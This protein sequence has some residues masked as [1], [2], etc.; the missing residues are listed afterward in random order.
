MSSLKH[1]LETFK[2]L[3]TNFKTFPFVFPRRAGIY[4]WAILQVYMYFMCFYIR[5]YGNPPS[6]FF[7]FSSSKAFDSHQYDHVTKGAAWNQNTKPHQF[8]LLYAEQ[9]SLRASSRGALAAGREKEGEPAT[10]S[11]EFEY[12]HRK[13]RY[14]M[15]IGGYDISN[16]VI[17]T[18]VITHLFFNVCSHSQLF[19]L[20]ANWRK[21]DSLVDGEPQGNWGWNSSSR[22]VVAS[23]PSFS[24]HARERPGKL[25]RRLMFFHVIVTRVQKVSSP[26]YPLKRRKF[27]FLV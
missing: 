14:E 5:C 26:S 1:I 10:T 13:S 2:H 17:T 21:S 4:G 18:Y 16:E 15:P 20:R 6:F 11:P 8:R 27:H 12:L 23:C 25:A 3:N 9:H 7:P 22:E 19:P 24:R